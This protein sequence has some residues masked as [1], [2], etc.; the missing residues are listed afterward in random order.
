M[1]NAHSS[2]AYRNLGGWGATRKRSLARPGRGMGDNVNR[3]GGC[4]LCDLAQ[5]RD[6]RWALLNMVVNFRVP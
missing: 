5:D 2:G 4:G 3:M 6:K 1:C